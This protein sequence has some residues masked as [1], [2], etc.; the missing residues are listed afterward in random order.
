[1]FD[2]V[3]LIVPRRRR[4][5]GL[6]LKEATM[7]A[8]V[9]KDQF[10]LG[11]Y[12]AHAPLR[13]QGQTD[14]PRTIFV[15]YS[16]KDEPWKKQLHPHLEQLA[17]A[18]YDLLVW[19]DRKIDA[20]ETWYPEIRQ[21]MER[22]AAAVCLISANYLSSKFCVREEVPFLL[23]QRER[24]GMLLVPIL[25]DECLWEDFNWLNPIQM[26][27]RDGQCL[28]LDF[29]GRESAVF[30]QVARRIRDFLKD[31]K[32]P[33]LPPAKAT[34][35]WPALPPEYIDLTRL[36]ET[37]FALFGRQDQ[38]RQLDEAWASGRTRVM[39]CVASGGMGKSTLANYWL[40]ERM[41]P[42]NFRGA[43]R[44]FGW[45]FYSQGTHTTPTSA[46]FFIN[47]A[48]IFFGDPQPDAGSPWDK[49]ERLARLAEGALLVLDGMEPLQTDFGADRGRV[50]DPALAGLMR[51]F[52]R[53]GSGMCLITTREPLTELMHRRETVQAMDLEHLS[54]EAGRAVLRTGGVIGT[55]AEL[56]ELARQ[57]GPHALA[58]TLLGSWL[59]EQ[60]GHR[61]AAAGLPELCELGNAEVRPVRCVLTGFEQLLGEGA[62]LEILRILGLFDRPAKPEELRALRTG[63]PLPGLTDHVRADLE[64][65]WERALKRLRQ[66]RLVARESTH[67]PGV[68]DAHPL[69]REHFGEQV[70]TRFPAAWKEGHNRL[71]EHLK[72]AAPEFPDTL[73]EM[74]PLF[75]G[76][77]HGCQAGRHQ[78]VCDDIYWHRIRRGREGY[79]WCKLGAFGSEVAA[80]SGFFEQLWDT[81]VPSLTEA[82]QAWLLNEAGFDLRALGRLAEAVQP[83]QATLSI[84]VAKKEWENA[85][86]SAGNLSEL[87]LTL[88]AV[89]EAERYARQGVDLADRSE[90]SSTRVV[91]RATLADALHQAG[92]WLEAE[93]TFREAEAMQ[94]EDQPKYPF[95][96]SLRGCQYCDL[97]LTRAAFGLL[98]ICPASSDPTTQ[99]QIGD[100]KSAIDLC[101]DVRKRAAQTLEWYK[102]AGEAWLLTIA[103]DHL[104][105]GRALL[106]EHVL[107]PEARPL[108]P[109]FEHL[110]AAVDGLWRAGQVQE[111]PH[112][113]LARAA[114][115]RVS[116]DLVGAG[117]DLAEA[118]ELAEHSGMK[119]FQV[120]CLIEEACQL[121][122]GSRVGDQGSAGERLMAARECVAK[123]KELI[124]STGYHRRDPEVRLLE[125]I[126]QTKS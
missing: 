71:Y 103:L 38:L 84:N 70:R 11:P 58:I 109:A 17:L 25:I 78:E 29:K 68:V 122:Q 1:M 8:D 39:V 61:P 104:G 102:A 56:E 53:A 50:T 77:A 100:R 111:L 66:L 69:V 67:H 13:A 79:S 60:P 22:A 112:G 44:V 90:V 89:G 7:P 125:Q 30:A 36:P 23:Q 98:L 27:P 15:S 37:G 91:N 31:G 16:H 95:L 5:V 82:A 124:E 106:L 18:G 43:R 117:H 75:A 72:Q 6:S 76:V 74:M 24:A 10:V 32:K 55:D 2:G 3:A 107:T 14:Q 83:L 54:P 34:L 114:L 63:D 87:N 51:A 121:I 81:P 110:N 46:D 40:R 45:T 9:E 59:H 86:I 20:G 49:G 113:L 62:E 118:R 41:T 105:L 123:A 12:D 19:D 33:D 120:D 88:G 73:E 126:L 47:Q 93:A 4:R 35:Q 116:G 64:T 101:R 26:L 119:L 65:N 42:D 97:L 80:I 96:Y 108:G 28:T 92:R 85:A 21:A 94:K 57:F 52:T 115:R 48:L 99:C